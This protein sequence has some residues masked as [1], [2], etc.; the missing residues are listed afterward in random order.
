MVVTACVCLYTFYIATYMAQLNPL[1]A[2]QVKTASVSGAQPT[3]R[4]VCA[5]ANHNSDNSAD[6]EPVPP[7]RKRAELHECR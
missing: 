3:S 5:G 1:I 7:S 4:R 2:P 6:L